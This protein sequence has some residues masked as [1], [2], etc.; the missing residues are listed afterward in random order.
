[1]INYVDYYLGWI[2]GF[3]G[4]VSICLI[5]VLI[6]FHFFVNNKFSEIKQVFSLSGGI[7]NGMKNPDSF[8]KN[9]EAASQLMKKK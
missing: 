8:L 4:G 2:S 1:M 6:Y 9:I 5:C 3:F 7:K